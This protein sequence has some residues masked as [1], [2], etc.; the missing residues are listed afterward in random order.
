M[1]NKLVG[2]LLLTASLSF[3]T[4]H[5]SVLNWGAATTVS[6]DSDVSTSGALVGA[7]NLVGGA[8]L[9]SNKTVNGVTFTSWDASL[10]PNTSGIFSFPQSAVGSYIFFNNA[11][12]FGSLSAE[13]RDLL[14]DGG[15]IPNGASLTISGL[16]IGQTYLFQW[17]STVP[18]PNNSTL[19]ASGTATAGNGVTLDPNITNAVGGLGQFAIGSFTADN[20]TQAIAF[21][22]G[23]TISAMQVRLPASSRS[24]P[25]SGT[26]LALFGVALASLI[27]V[28]RRLQ[29]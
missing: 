23:S 17:W 5:A 19:N 11:A 7:V 26:T 4:G 20:T 9:P 29:R 8:T 25:D 13:Y 3:S 1:V 10:S 18:D 12:P 24:V 2:A 6:G 15:V 27:G 28:R 22:A 21:S 16:T 14:R